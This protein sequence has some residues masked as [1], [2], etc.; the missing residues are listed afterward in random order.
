[1]SVNISASTLLNQ[2]STTGTYSFSTTKT[3]RTINEYKLSA[4]DDCTEIQT[5]VRNLR[6]TDVSFVGDKAKARKYIKKFISSFNELKES[7]SDINSKDYDRAVSKLSK[8]I[9]NY[10]DDLEKLG[11][12]KTKSGSLSFDNLKWTELEGEKFEKN[13]N[14]IFG[15][16]SDFSKN[17]EKYIKSVKSASNQNLLQTETIVNRT[18]VD[19]SENKISMAGA[20]NNLSS[21]ISS[22]SASSEESALLC[23]KEIISN[24]NL[25]FKKEK[26]AETNAPALNNIR[27]LITSNK[28]TLNE[29]GIDC[30]N[31]GKT[32]YFTDDDETTFKT[33]YN[34]AALLFS[35]NFGEELNLNLKDLF[36]QLL[37]TDSHSVIVDEYR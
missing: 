7:A 28:S 25:I 13:F 21:Y 12:K 4:K 1:M 32:I 17:I 26:E 20:A 14:K 19:I 33:K 30:D 16:D 3:K 36:C 9:D 11:I 22:F 27:D 2:L 5:A 29:I 31:E 35:G 34:D 23:M 8:V 15:N 10:S 24:Y 18:S 37:E 6:K